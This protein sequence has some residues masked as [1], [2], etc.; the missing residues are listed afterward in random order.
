MASLAG[1]TGTLSLAPYNIAGRI[2]RASDGNGLDG[3][4]AQVNGASNVATTGEGG[5]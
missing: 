3:I 4:I 1:C 5:N 2:T